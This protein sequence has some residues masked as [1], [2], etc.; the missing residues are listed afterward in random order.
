VLASILK[1]DHGKMDPNKEEIHVSY[2]ESSR[3]SLQETKTSP[4]LICHIW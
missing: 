2:D 3:W 1:G 4:N